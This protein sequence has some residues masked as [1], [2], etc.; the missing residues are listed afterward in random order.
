MRATINMRPPQPK[1]KA[2]WTEGFAPKRIRPPP[3][4]GRR[5]YH[6]STLSFGARKA[7]YTAPPMLTSEWLQETAARRVTDTGVEPGALKG[8]LN[9]G[10]SGFARITTSRRRA[11]STS[12]QVYGGESGIRTHEH[13]L[14]CYW[15]SS[16][17]PSTAR[18]SLR[19]ST[20]DDFL[21]NLQLSAACA[22]RRMIHR[23]ACGGAC[24]GTLKGGGS[25]RQRSFFFRGGGAG[26]F[27]AGMCNALAVSG[28]SRPG[29]IFRAATLADFM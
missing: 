9:G 10:E 14:R 19:S 20:C 5:S 8:A 28:V 27:S 16:P 15:N 26:V 11:P 13:P 18:P 23:H 2:A 22:R 1:P 3:H 12:V 24:F 7:A 21:E 25:S 17:A 4:Q 29:G 6:G